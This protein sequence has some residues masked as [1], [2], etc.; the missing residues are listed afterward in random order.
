[1]MADAQPT[2]R[3][4]LFV[5]VGV[6]MIGTGLYAGLRS[7]QAAQLSYRWRRWWIRRMSFGKLGPPACA[8]SSA[9]WS[10]TTR[11]YFAER[12]ESS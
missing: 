12:L 2:F 6:G 3:I 5:V 9:R 4:I 1:M 10:G 7:E 8:R 11:R